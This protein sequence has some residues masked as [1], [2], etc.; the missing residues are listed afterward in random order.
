MRQVL[1]P[2]AGHNIPIIVLS[3]VGTI[4]GLALGVGLL[5]V[6]NPGGA[7][8]MAFAGV[9]IGSA[10]A[11]YFR[12]AMVWFDDQEV[13]KVNLFG[14]ETKLRREQLGRLETRFAPQPTLNFLRKDGSRAFRINTRLWTDAQVKAMK[15]AVGG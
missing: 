2:G 1:R 4:A 10:C 12:N 3:A 13:G 6:S 7:A 15:D 8:F 5:T 14:V 9:A 11:A